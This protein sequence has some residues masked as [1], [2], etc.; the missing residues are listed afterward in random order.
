MFITER[1]GMR[2]NKKEKILLHSKGV[3]YFSKK[4]ERN[5]FFIM[6]II[7]IIWTVIIRFVS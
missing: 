4:T 5:F 7:M 6:T 1:D 3:T 2:E